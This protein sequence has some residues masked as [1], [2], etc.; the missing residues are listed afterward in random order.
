MLSVLVM[1]CAGESTVR[2]IPQPW[3]AGT[4]RAVSV[5]GQP[6]PAHRDTS[7]FA[8][9]YDSLTLSVGTGRIHSFYY[10]GASRGEPSQLGCGGLVD[11]E[12]RGDTIRIV[13]PGSLNSC[14]FLVLSDRR[15]IRRANFLVHEWE[16]NRFVL[17]K[18]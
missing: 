2:P 3:F 5:N 15:F 14:G 16:G 10:Y 17:T 1:G 18:P 12:H 9:R 4:W 8:Y 11:V 13:S 7:R 6:L